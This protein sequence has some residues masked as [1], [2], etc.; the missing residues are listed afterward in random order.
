[1]SKSRGIWR[2]RS[3]LSATLD[4]CKKTAGKHWQG[5]DAIVWPAPDGRRNG[6]L[7]AAQLTDIRH[8][9][10]VD[11]S[12]KPM[13]LKKF[14]RTLSIGDRIR[15]IC[16]DGVLVAEK[17]SERQFRVIHSQMMSKFVH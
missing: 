15:V 10:Q 12:G 2:I 5:T 9:L 7:E 6:P 11:S 17:I 14:V 8:S 3:L 4:W 1:M 13:E 16:D